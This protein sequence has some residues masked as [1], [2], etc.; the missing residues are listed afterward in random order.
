NALL[1]IR[2][3]QGRL[4]RWR[5][6]VGQSGDVNID[7]R[8]LVDRAM[9]HQQ[10]RNWRCNA[11]LSRHPEID[12]RPPQVI[13]VAA[14]VMTLSACGASSDDGGPPLDATNV[15]EALAVAQA[16]GLEWEVGVL[17]DGTVTAGEYE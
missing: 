16:E 3:P 4:P 15:A 2:H 7:R 17:E 1:R 12:M 10:L 6:H 11:P 5:A 9:G 14:L 8:H 13:A